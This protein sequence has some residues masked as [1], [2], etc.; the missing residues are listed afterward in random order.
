MRNMILTKITKLII[1]KKHQQAKESKE[2][3]YQA[4]K[5]AA[6]RPSDSVRVR[7][8]SGSA[9]FPDDFRKYCVKVI[10]F[11]KN[12]RK[13]SGIH[14][15]NLRKTYGNPFFLVVQQRKNFTCERANLS[16]PALLCGGS[17]AKRSRICFALSMINQITTGFKD[18]FPEEGW[19]DQEII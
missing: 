1:S 14:P 17:S 4:G 2:G 11:S 9:G 10:K 16:R 7:S 8:F 19:G 3:R 15:E 5:K 13:P 6:S 12:S 18:Q